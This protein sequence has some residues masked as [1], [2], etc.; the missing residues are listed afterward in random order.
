MVI[1]LNTSNLYV[2]GGVQVAL[3]FLNVIKNIYT[4]NIY[5]IFL[6]TAI[7]DQIIQKEF[8]DNM[9]FYIIEKSPSAIKSR[10]KIVKKLKLLENRIDPDVV[11]S[12]FGPTY[13]KP[14]ALHI[15]GFAN[16]WLYNPKSIAYTRLKLFKRMQMRMF[17]LYQEYYL[18]RDANFIIVETHDAKD[19]ISKIL[20]IETNKIFV[21]GNTCS[22]IFKDKKYIE[23]GYKHYINL[24]K[25]DKNEYRLLYIA[26]NHPNKNLEIINEVCDLLSEKNVNFVVTIDN[27][28]YKSIF[29][30]NLRVTNLGPVV[31]ESCPSIYSQCDFLFAPT[32]LE[33]FS[34][35]YPEAMSM[36]LPI[37]TSKY[38]FAVDVCQNSALYFDPTNPMDIAKKINTLIDNTDL[39]KSMIR[40][41]KAILSQMET[42]KTRAE[43]YLKICEKQYKTLK[44][45]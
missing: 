40:S 12:V 17:C 3:S 15:M 35:S 33:T 25:K 10:N 6:S 8:P 22:S 31:H 13:W 29:S 18:K 27:E 28:S 20:S 32:L 38:S 23:K 21:V 5:H 26:H 9:H 7:A 16:G 4:K 2:G 39:Q 42:G 45:Y 24:P 34:A 41:G 1:I 44:A 36:N 30:N 43:K 37:L 11:F 14:K 19:K